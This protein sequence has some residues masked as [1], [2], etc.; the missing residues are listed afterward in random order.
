MFERG[1]SVIPEEMPRDLKNWLAEKD[2]PV[3]SW[4]RITGGFI[5]PIFRLRVRYKSGVERDMVY[6]QFSHGRAREFDLSDNVWGALAAYA[7]PRIARIHADEEKGLLMEDAGQP[8]KA[9]L[10]TVDAA[11]RLTLLQDAVKWLASLHVKLEKKSHAWLAL[12]VMDTYPVA[13]ARAWANDAVNGLTWL[14]EQGF[15]EI[16]EVQ[17]TQVKDMMERFYPSLAYLL[18]G[19]NTVTHG[20][21]HMEN[22]LLRRE[23]FCLIDWEYSCVTVPQRDITILLQD[24]LTSELH[25]AARNTY[26]EY[27]RQHGWSVDDDAFETT[28]QA[29]LFDNTLMM[30]GWEIFKFRRGFLSQKELECIVAT[31]LKWLHESFDY[32]SKHVSL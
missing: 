17:L 14:T 1:G 4:G 12:G 30:L 2:W 6:K 32:L 23:K 22:L 10:G 27:L 20:D 8:I 16:N 11:Q 15:Q 29:C 5:A 18:K 13:S 26:W 28:Y 9:R 19:R 7:P 24:V 31:K 21:P 25:Q 3:I